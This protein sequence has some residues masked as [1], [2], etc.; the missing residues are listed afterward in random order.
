MTPRGSAGDRLAAILEGGGPPLGRRGKGRARGRAGDET[1]DDAQGGGKPNML[2]TGVSRYWGER[3]ALQIE[4]TSD[5]EAVYGIDV[6]PP[7][8]NFRRV[9]FTHLDIRSPMILDFLISRRIQT[10]VHLQSSSSPDAEE[11][12]QR[13]V[14]DTMF[15]LSACADAGVRNVVLRSD[16]A[17]Y[18][19]QPDNPARIRETRYLI[20][21]DSPFLD[22]A[23]GQ[24]PRLTNLLEV[25]KYCFKFRSQNPQI[26]VIPLRFAPIL[27]PRCNTWISRYLREPV[28]PTALGFDPLIQVI[29]EDDVVRAM[30]AAAASDLNGPVNV[31]A[32]GILTLHQ[33]IRRMGGTSVPFARPL[34]NLWRRFRRAFTGELLAPLGMDSLKYG[35]I[36]DLQRM[37]DELRFEPKFSAAQTLDNFSEHRRMARYYHESE[38]EAIYG[39]YVEDAL[40]AILAEDSLGM[41]EQ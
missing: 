18:G 24:I 26:K 29:H 41:E 27:G 34:G 38:P 3:L 5:F 25:E 23:M 21:K 22:R 13:N 7:R 31:A 37:R 32:P 17:V 9:Q 15:L 6:Q 28:I 30:L 4:R 14:M 16:T 2:I 19:F 35:C 10:V 8:V 1:R 20:K 11:L 40:K 12:F 33:L 39:K 36:G